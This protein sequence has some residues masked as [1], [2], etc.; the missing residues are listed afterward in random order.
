MTAIS[1]L[2]ESVLV[3]L[4]DNSGF[5]AAR[6]L[7]SEAFGRHIPSVHGGVGKNAYIEFMKKCPGLLNV[8]IKFEVY[9]LL[10]NWPATTSTP[11]PAAEPSLYKLLSAENVADIYNLH[12]LFGLENL[13]TL[14][15]GVYP[16]VYPISIGGF[17][18][19]M[20]DCWPV[21]KGLVEWIREGF[22]VKG[23]NV[24]V[25]LW[26]VGNPRMRLAGGQRG[27]GTR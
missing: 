6:K 26:E 21:M 8:T 1:R 4:P 16:E 10:K 9:Y 2:L 24:D 14:V 12:G 13:R 27:V 15:V 19:Y 7:S 25:I 3:N 20:P 11:L 5:D 23:M 22:R 17:F 18:E